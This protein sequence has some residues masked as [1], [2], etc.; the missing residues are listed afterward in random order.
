[1][2]PK[3][4]T[5]THTKRSL[6]VGLVA[7]SLG[8]IGYCGLMVSLVQPVSA[9]PKPI[10]EPGKSRTELER[11]GY[12]C[13]PVKGKEHIILCIK[14][15]STYYCYAENNTC[16]PSGDIQTTSSPGNY[17]YNIQPGGFNSENVIRAP[18]NNP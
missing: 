18:Y 3:T 10:V 8:L 7:A 4:K 17:L 14:G 13:G 9:L 6:A 1:M 5:E 12:L 2:I 11:E 16:F 15:N